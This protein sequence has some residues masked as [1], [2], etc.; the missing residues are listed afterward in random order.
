MP[1][2]IMLKNPQKI[3]MNNKVIPEGHPCFWCK[4]MEVAAANFRDKTIFN[5]FD[6]NNQINAREILVSEATVPSM[7]K[8]SGIKAKIK[9]TIKRSVIAVDADFAGKSFIIFVF[10]LFILDMVKQFLYFVF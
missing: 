10:K 7:A 4:K 9:K 5:I 8:S 1:H 6:K 2:I 3:I